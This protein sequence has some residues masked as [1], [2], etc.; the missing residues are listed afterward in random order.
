MALVTFK[1]T[2]R[3]L[4][5][6]LA[7]ESQAR[8]FKIVMDEPETLGGTDTGINPVETLLCAL[9]ACQTIV[10]MA[11]AQSQNID[12]QDFWVDVEGDLDPDG[13]MKGAPGIRPGFQE[14]RFTMHIKSNSPED[15]LQAFQKFIESRCPVG[16][17]LSKGVAIKPGKIVIEK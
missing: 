11:F 2:T 13:F 7:V 12:L 16:D 6:G 3:K 1:S 5:G 8:N 10:A 15:K 14:V 17:T 9:G 4:K